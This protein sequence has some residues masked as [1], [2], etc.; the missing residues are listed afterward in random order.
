MNNKIK[1]KFNFYKMNSFPLRNSNNLKSSRTTIKYNN[2]FSTIST[3]RTIDHDNFNNFRYLNRINYNTLKNPT[4]KNYIPFN[5]NTILKFEIKRPKQ[6][7]NSCNNYDINKMKLNLKNE[8]KN[9][10]SIQRILSTL[11]THIRK[12]PISLHETKTSRN[13]I[14][15]NNLN[16]NKENR[17]CKNLLYDEIYD[18][19]I[20]STNNYFQITNENDDKKELETKK[21]QTIDKKDKNINN[22][23]YNKN[24]LI[25]FSQ[26]EINNSNQKNIKFDNI[27]KEMKDNK[28]IKNIKENLFYSFK[29]D[30]SEK[31]NSNNKNSEELVKSG[32]NTEKNIDN[33]SSEKKIISISNQNTKDNKLENKKSNN[34]N[35]NNKRFSLEDFFKQEILNAT[36]SKDD[37]SE[38]STSFI[39]IN[40]VIRNKNNNL[41]KNRN[42][43]NYGQ[44]I[45]DNTSFYEKNQQIISPI[46]NQSSFCSNHKNINENEINLLDFSIKKNSN[47][48]ND[49]IYKNK[50]ISIDNY[51]TRNRKYNIPINNNSKKQTYIFELNSI[52]NIFN[53]NNNINNKKLISNR[54]LDSKVRLLNNNINFIT[55]YSGE[56]KN[57]INNNI[58]DRNKRIVSL[59]N[60]KNS[61]F[62][63]KVRTT[64]QPANI[65]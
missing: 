63:R 37:D 42:K 48:Y 61:R 24:N 3:A 31:N 44:V 16:K 4:T 64:V 32:N 50:Y 55:I 23:T 38:K 25:T 35:N 1:I 5:L 53:K 13:K 28:D 20:K 45:S 62:N 29:K 15:N 2:F 21:K 10:G 47:K 60:S 57:D 65:F 33:S 7:S 41:P 36:L 54:F 52:S 12:N 49:N 27:G 59:I 11:N 39:K 22:C 30:S 43:R 34:K 18:Y 6:I 26:K 46:L 9:F 40:D 14:S 17:N 58:L 8:S 56:D 19:S 51:K